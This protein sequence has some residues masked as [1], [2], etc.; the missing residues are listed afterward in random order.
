[1]IE[2]SVLGRINAY[3]F[4]FSPVQVCF[5]NICDIICFAL[6]YKKETQMKKIILGSVLLSSLLLAQN[7]DKDF[8]NNLPIVKQGNVKVEK[9][10]KL[11]G[12]Y[13]VKGTPAQAAP[14]QPLQP[15]EFF[16]TENFKQLI[17]GRAIDT[18]NGQ[19]VRFPVD[20]SELKGK[21]AITY[22]TGKK[23]LYVFTDPECPYCKTFEKKIPSLKDKYT[24]KIFLFPLSFHKNA[25]PMSKYIL[26]AKSEKEKFER[27]LEIANESNK[28]QDL[29]LSPEENKELDGLIK[30][31]LDYGRKAEVSGT[32]TVMDTKGSLVDW[33]KL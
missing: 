25:I 1:M 26:A 6:K 4:L 12:I 19:P 13:H 8:L 30:K 18:A 14:N 33:P 5:S 28:Y 9:F 2:A 3:F 16:L 7:V 32:P 24:F 23:V 31:Q 22:G 11:D 20:L 27:L 21:E 29:K 10:Q 17:M 15:I